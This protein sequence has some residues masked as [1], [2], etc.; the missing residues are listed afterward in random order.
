MARTFLLYPCVCFCLGCA[1]DPGASAP[2]IGREGVGAAQA[3]PADAPRRQIIV[4]SNLDLIAEDFDRASSSV[5]QLVKDHAG[6]VAKADIQGSPGDRRFGSWTLRVPAEKVGTF[7]H[8]LQ[9]L[10]EVV[11]SS[12]DTQDVTDQFYDLQARTKNRKAEEDALRSLLE[13]PNGKY[14]D[15]LATRKMLNEVRREIEVEEGQLKRLQLLTALATTNLTMTSRNNYVP[16]E[17]PGFGTSAGAGVCAVVAS[18]DRLCAR[19]WFGLRRG[20]AVGLGPARGRATPGAGRPRFAGEAPP[21]R[22]TRPARSLTP[23]I[24]RRPPPSAPASS[25]GRNARRPRRRGPPRTW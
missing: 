25:A 23:V 18:P 17:S 1:G 22:G 3:P 20:G 9:G 24:S 12:T 19:R 8:A 7:L 11:R 16:P 5:E 6:Y 2:R 14:E 10:G 4:T 15:M 21:A 13:K